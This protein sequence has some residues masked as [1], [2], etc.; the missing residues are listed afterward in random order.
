M[1]KWLIIF[2]NKIKIILNDIG[3]KQ[4]EYLTVQEISDKWAISK[5]RIQ[6]LWKEGRIPD[7]KMIGNMWLMNK[8]GNR[9]GDTRIKSTNVRNYD[10]SEIS[11]VR[12]E[13]K[14]V[15]KLLHAS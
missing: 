10:K 1:R 3:G 12:K 5:R 6:I 7:A 14:K 8:D 9:R 15:H 13:L 11:Q 2:A 4:M